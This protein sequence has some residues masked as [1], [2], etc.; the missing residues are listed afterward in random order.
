MRLYLDF[1][2]LECVFVLL[3]LFDR[4]V[5]LSVVVVVKVDVIFCSYRSYVNFD[6]SHL[7]SASSEVKLNFE[8]DI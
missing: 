7:I 1:E 8:S 4:N 2:L 3:L 6:F 5:G